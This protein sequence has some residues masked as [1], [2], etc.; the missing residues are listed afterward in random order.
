MSNYRKHQR[1]ILV[2][3]GWGAIAAYQG[4]IQTFLTVSVLTD[5]DDLLALSPT[6][7]SSKL[8]DMTG[9]LIVFAGYKRIVSSDILDRNT[10]INI[11]YSLLPK[12]RGFHSTVWAI[13]NDEQELGL[14]V[15]LMNRYIDDGPIIAQYRVKNDFISTST[16]YMLLFNEYIKNHLGHIIIDFINGNLVPVLQDKSLAS[17]VG[18]RNLEDCRIDFNQTLQYLKAFFRALVPPYPIPYF[19]RQCKKY[20]VVEVDF[21][22]SPVV[23]H[24][25]RIL[26]IDHDGLWIKVQDG[27]L[28]IKSVVDSENNPVALSEEFR[29]GQFVNR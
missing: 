22:S 2:G 28:V 27:Y 17:W 7:L 1:V 20:Y 3:D 24:T 29:I 13:L 12:Y 4:L 10:C 18:K 11:H 25:G 21:F 6:R 9:E 23:T 8:D 26:N 14:S 16:H 5:D 15:H 19:E